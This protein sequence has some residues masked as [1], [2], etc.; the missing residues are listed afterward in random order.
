MSI[1][2]KITSFFS[3][4]EDRAILDLDSSVD[5]DS[6]KTAGNGQVGKLVNKKGNVNIDNS[7]HNYF[8]INLPQGIKPGT[9]DFD[10]IKDE[11]RKQFNELNVQ[12]LTEQS[13]KIVIG[14]KDFEQ[15]SPYS[16]IADFF[17]DKISTT[18][19]QFLRTGLYVRYLSDNGHRDEAIKIKDESIRNNPRA[20]NIINLASAG[21]F[22]EYIQPIFENNDKVTFDNEYEEVVNYLPEIIFVN[23]SMT[24]D[25]IMSE[26]DKKLALSAQYHLQVQCIMINGLNQCVQRIRES[27]AIIR[28]K[29]P[30]YKINLQTDGS[31]KTLLRG[32]MRI[33]LPIPE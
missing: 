24:V 11:L 18:D 21:Y 7:T 8:R 31:S 6:T 27:E 12:F 15:S 30:T 5:V 10:D 17:T 32:K 25:K 26:L 1:I 29:Y 4:K 33:E 19:L 13:D 23:N 3:S 14:F 28:E 2:D 22:E 20:R 9:K 16:K